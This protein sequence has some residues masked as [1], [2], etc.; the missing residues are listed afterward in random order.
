MFARLRGLAHQPFAGLSRCRSFM[1]RFA[2]A[3]DLRN[4]P[5][6]IHA[7]SDLAAARDAS[8]RVPVIGIFERGI[9]VVANR[10]I[11]T[12]GFSRAG[13][14]QWFGNAFPEKRGESVVLATAPS[15]WRPA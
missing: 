12:P 14:T 7:G 3:H 9:D 5:G 8:R 2:A 1:R 11:R 6:D 13:V 10:R 15:P 4:Q